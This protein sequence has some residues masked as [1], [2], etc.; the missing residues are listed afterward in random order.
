MIKKITIDFDISGTKIIVPFE[1]VCTITS[2]KFQGFI[3]CEYHPKKEVLEYVDL[4]RYTK[5]VTKDM[6][7]AEELAHR[8]YIEIFNTISP[9]YLKVTVDVKKTEAHQPVEVWVESKKY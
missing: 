4:E 9:A 7:T 3:V 6:L 1:A 5:D 8:V 2:K